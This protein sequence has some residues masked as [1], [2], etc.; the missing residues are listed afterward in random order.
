M[1]FK[2]EQGFKIIQ[3]EETFIGK[4]KLKIKKQLRKIRQFSFRNCV[5]LIIEKV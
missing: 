5:S 3:R 4:L 1:R 2:Q